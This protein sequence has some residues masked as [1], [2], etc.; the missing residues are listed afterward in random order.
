[1]VSSAG[2]FK[3]LVH[4]SIQMEGSHASFLRFSPTRGKAVIQH[5]GGKIMKIGFVH[6]LS[7]LTLYIL[8]VGC[9]PALRKDAR[10]VPS[11]STTGSK[12]PV[13]RSSPSSA[14]TSLPRTAEVDLVRLPLLKTIFRNQPASSRIDDLFA[15]AKDQVDNV[16]LVSN[17]DLNILK[18]FVAA[19]W[20][21]VV[22]LR[23]E[24]QPWVLVGYDDAVEQVQL[25]NIANAP[26]R[27]T[28]PRRLT[29]RRVGYSDFGR[30]W[31]SG[32]CMLVAAGPLMETK[33]R[34]VLAQ[35]L[36]ATHA[37]QVKVRSR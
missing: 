14:T 9:G 11:A 3:R 13:S 37:S 17:C 27:T 25:T 23:S 15:R 20:T 28:D 32:K 18:G 35:Y 10:Y 19:G 34:S 21:P 33:V 1:M 22:L 16:C 8:L 36:T 12:S 7:I 2:K 4:R 5:R 31:A 6:L 24:R 29:L 26:L 30:E